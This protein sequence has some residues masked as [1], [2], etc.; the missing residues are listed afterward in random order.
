MFDN[1]LTRYDNPIQFL[2]AETLTR[3][4]AAKFF[5]NFALYMW[6]TPIIWSES[7]QFNDVVDADWTLTP[8]ILSSCT[9]GLFKWSQG[10]FMPFDTLTRAEALTV[11][12]RT[13]KGKQDE[14]TIPRWS[15]YHKLAR[16]LGL[17]AENDVYS[18]DAPITRYEIALILWRA[19]WENTPDLEHA[20]SQAQIDELKSLLLTLWLL[21]Q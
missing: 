6:K 9:L 16:Q 11:V 13:L 4:Q 1:E 15:N 17:T 14:T 18:L 12:I 8:H 20:A 10:N 19:S 7:C 21:T 3:E 5:W 2:P